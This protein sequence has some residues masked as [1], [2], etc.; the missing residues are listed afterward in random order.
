M[1][2]VMHLILLLH[3]QYGTPHLTL[4]PTQYDAP[5]CLLAYTVWCPLSSSHM[6]N[7]MPLVVLTHTMQHSPPSSSG[8]PKNVGARKVEHPC[9]DTHEQGGALLVIST[10]SALA[11]GIASVEPAG[12]AEIATATKLKALVPWVQGEPGHKVDSLP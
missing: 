10:A 6:H 1:H 8:M 5:C 3:V 7:V 4:M 9:I 12:K 2:N 11:E